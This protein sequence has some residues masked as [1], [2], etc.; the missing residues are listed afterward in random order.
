M[1]DPP[2]TVLR[3]KTVSLMKSDDG[4]GGPVPVSSSGSCT[5]YKM[6]PDGRRIICITNAHVVEGAIG[7]VM[8]ND[9][10][11]GKYEI[12]CDV[13][14]ASRVE[15]ADIAVICSVD[16]PS[17]ILKEKQKRVLSGEG[18]VVE[19]LDRFWKSV[20][21]LRQLP[22]L[23]KS[24]EENIDLGEVV[25]AG[26]P[27]NSQEL[28]PTEGTVTSQFVEG[29]IVWWF[30][31]GM[32]PGNSG[33]GAFTKDGLFL[34]VPF[35]GILFASVVGYIIPSQEA[36]AVADH[37]IKAFDGTFVN[38]EPM[39]VGSTRALLPGDYVDVGAVRLVVMENADSQDL[40]IYASISQ[41]GSDAS[42]GLIAP[43]REWMRLFPPGT[44]STN[45]NGRVISS[46]DINVPVRFIFPGMENV[47]YEA[48][49]GVA[50]VDMNMSHIE[51]FPPLEDLGREE[52]RVVVSYIDTESS[53][54]D[55][56]SHLGSAVI[57]VEDQLVFSVTEVR[58]I[59]SSLPNAES[60][61]LTTTQGTLTL[62]K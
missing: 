52:P 37:I 48:V 61:T 19:G 45:N 16:I 18:S 40:T 1:A 60:V 22:P 30:T 42:P 5:V 53:N 49:G 51:R 26:F 21:P 39:K 28:V 33:G 23:V 10:S 44:Y 58:D 62:V 31:G 13:W 35:A 57:M 2:A 59:L 25:V 27:F 14:G 54:P 41:R 47:Q 34:G 36:I 7:R 24:L 56:P 43:L 15:E 29:R 8:I 3:V 4:D 12:P 6:T 55:L 20:T 9:P 50:L 11:L 17:L 38:L 32:N 46:Y